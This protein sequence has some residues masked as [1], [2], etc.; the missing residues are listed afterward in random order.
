M[1]VKSHH[2]HQHH[3]TSQLLN[4]LIGNYVCCGLCNKEVITLTSL[5]FR[6][7]PVPKEEEE[8]EGASGGGR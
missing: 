4:Q 7:V 1:E 3:E 2:Q 8:G 6:S 5:P